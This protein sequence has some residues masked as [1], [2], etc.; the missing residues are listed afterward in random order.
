MSKT[1]KKRLSAFVVLPSRRESHSRGSG[2]APVE[3]SMSV[4][5][6]CRGTSSPE[7][8]PERMRPEPKDGDLVRQG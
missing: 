8:F 3:G 7:G 6:Q 1:N 2:F 4:A 5:A